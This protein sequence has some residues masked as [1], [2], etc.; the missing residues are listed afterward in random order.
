MNF[1]KEMFKILKFYILANTIVVSFAFVSVQLYLGS[2][3]AVTKTAQ[4]K[5]LSS[6]L[7]CENSEQSLGNK[8]SNKVLASSSNLLVDSLAKS[9]ST[10][11]IIERSFSLNKFNKI[12]IKIRKILILKKSRAPPLLILS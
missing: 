1:S 7:F 12:E 3:D 5:L 4:H 11:L 9:T 6:F 2:S 8:K 10:I